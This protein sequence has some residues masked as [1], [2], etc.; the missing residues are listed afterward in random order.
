MQSSLL[1]LRLGV[2]ILTAV[3]LT[4]VALGSDVEKTLAS[5]SGLRG[6]V[7]QC[8]EQ[9]LYPAQGDV[10]ERTYT[11]TSIYSPDGSLLQ[12]RTSQSPEV[13]YVTTYTYDADGQLLRITSSTS[14]PDAEQ[15]SATYSYDDKGRLVSISSGGTVTTSYEYDEYGQKRRVQHYPVRDAEP[16]AAVSGVQWENSDLH[17][18]SPS[19][20]T[21]TTIYDQRDRPAEAKVSDANERVTLRIVR[22]YDEQGRLRGDKLIPEDMESAIPDELGALMN[23]AQKKAVAKFLA[24]SFGSGESAYKYDAQG[25]VIEKRVT[26]GLLGNEVTMIRYND[27]GDVSAEESNRTPTPEMNAA[28]GVDEAG[29]MAPVSKSKGLGPSRTDVR[30]AYEY[31]AQG[32]WTQKTVSVRSESDGEF[33]VS[34]TTHRTLTYY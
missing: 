15:F 10:A 21:I 32:N 3:L 17:F 7:K 9:T 16:N 30:Y 33:N 12:S 22:A 13:D 20:G 8:I 24:R 2:V 14:T 31:D 25:R 1:R 29:N 19:G 23:D 28:F 4:S 5:H 34:M 11:S 6:R 27:G 26:G 18:G